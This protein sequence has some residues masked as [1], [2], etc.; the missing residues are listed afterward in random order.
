MLQKPPMLCW[1]SD[2]LIHRSVQKCCCWWDFAADATQNHHS[3]LKTDEKTVKVDWW[4][5]FLT[6]SWKLLARK[7]MLWQ[8][9]YFHTFICTSNCITFVVLITHLIFYIAKINNF[10]YDLASWYCCN[11]HEVLPQ[12]RLD[13]NCK[14][15]CGMDWIQWPQYLHVGSQ[16][17]CVIQPKEQLLYTWQVY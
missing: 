9:T 12:S 11:H 2:Q 4:R 3:A 16:L 6:F 14:S 1:W 17:L 15:G 5:M 8:Y 10:D 13:V 7:L